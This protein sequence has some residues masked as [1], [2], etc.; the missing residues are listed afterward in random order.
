MFF[1]PPPV[2]LK[3]AALHAKAPAT[4]DV[5]FTT[6]KGTFVVTVHRAW[7]PHGADRFYNLVKGRFFDG[8]EFFRVVSGFVVQFG[9]SGYPAVSS[10][11]QNATIEDDPVKAS[12]TP[13]TITFADGGPNTR[14]TQVF[15]NLGNNA[16]NLD[17]QGFAPF[18]KVTK[19]MSVVR[20]LFAGYG[21]QV[22]NL[23]G[24]I[25]TQG[26]AFLKKRFPKLDAVIR[27]RLVK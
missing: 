9:L 11:W 14:T 19:G 2:L 22:T 21:E 23:Q 26:N 13:G 15:I 7:A 12:N 27:A 5:S 3:P 24:Q 17:G 1:A 16:A 20:K 6:T 25:A 10:A 8:D 4:Y 18:G